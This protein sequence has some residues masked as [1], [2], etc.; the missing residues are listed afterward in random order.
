MA[1]PTK[2]V[3]RSTSLSREEK[4]KEE[5]KV[6]KPMTTTKKNPS[7]WFS[8]RT[9]IIICI[10]IIFRITCAVL[11]FVFLLL[12]KEVGKP[13]VYSK[14]FKTWKEACWLESF[15]YKCLTG[16]KDIRI[17]ITE[18]NIDPLN[19]SILGGIYYFGRDSYFT[20]VSK[21]FRVIELVAY[22]KV[23]R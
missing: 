19:N 18:S 10:I 22:L 1:S 2:K 9:K 13:I 16:N 15:I 4:N 12:S 7:N 5:V 6:V 8:T 17:E 20:K 3:H 11:Y 23:S 21:I 14:N